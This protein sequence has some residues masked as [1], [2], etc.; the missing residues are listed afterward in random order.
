MMMFVAV[1]RL[2]LR[3][4]GWAWIAP[5]LAFPT[6]FWNVGVGQNAFLSAGLLGGFILLID[7]RPGIAG[8]LLGMLC[9]K[10]H[11][12]L[13]APLALAAGGHWRAFF[14]A[15]LAV[16]VLVAATIALFGW[17][18]WQAYLAAFAGSLAI[19]QSG[20]IDFAG[21]VSVFGAVM[22]SGY[23]AGHA[24]VAQA[25]MAVL[26]A[27][28]VVLFWRGGASRPQRGAALLA[29]TLLAVPVVLIY[30]QLIA[31]VAMGWLV[32]EGREQ[33]FMPWEKILLFALYP[34][35]LLTWSIGTAWHTP[36]GPLV[37]LLILI[38]CLR[39]LW[40]TQSAASAVSLRA[41][42]EGKT[43]PMPRRMQRRL[44]ST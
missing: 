37:S 25:I 34:L 33:G 42:V 19:Y 24:T 41:R 40:R 1:M 31:L 43:V 26:V 6:V 21:M 29:A 32:R 23:S 35:T 16:A 44:R 10:P 30:D 18:T 3:A 14:S 11:F 12:G 39:R 22:L 28:L 27:G 4:R 7:R 38:L 17:E 5:L 8:M 36:L 2:V 9:Y 13:L 20:S 15:A